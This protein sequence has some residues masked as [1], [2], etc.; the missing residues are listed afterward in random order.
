VGNGS[1]AQAD[2]MLTMRTN[3]TCDV[4]FANCADIH[5]E[6]VTLK[7]IASFQRFNDAAGDSSS[8]TK[9]ALP[10]GPNEPALLMRRH[11]LY[12]S[13]AAD[14]GFKIILFTCWGRLSTSAKSISWQVVLIIK[15]L[16]PHRCCTIPA[17]SWREVADR[18]INTMCRRRGERS[19]DFDDAAASAI[20][21]AIARP[22]PRD[23][24]LIITKAEPEENSVLSAMML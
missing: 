16:S 24:P 11:E 8:H 22:I 2:D 1:I 15:E 20:A 4:A 14:S 7:S 19:F 21:R 9:V 10:R 3:G 6:E 23:A 5:I 18:A 12:F 17:V 13:L